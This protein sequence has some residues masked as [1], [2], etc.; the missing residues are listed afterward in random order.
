MNKNWGKR[1]GILLIS[2]IMML[3]L[4]AC[5]GKKLV[6]N[7]DNTAALSGEYVYVPTFTPI[8]IADKG[9]N[10]GNSL[11][12]EEKLYYSLNT[13]HPEM[14]RNDFK[15]IIADVSDLSKVETVEIQAP[16]LEDYKINMNT[17][18]IDA[19][20]NFYVL[21]DVLPSLDDSAIANT[22]AHTTY[23]VKY[24]SNGNKVYEQDLKDIFKDKNSS[25]VQSFQ[26]SKD[27]KLFAAC[28]HVIYVIDADGIHQKS[29]TTKTEW[30]NGLVSTEDGRL[31]YAQTGNKDESMEL[32]EIDTDKYT[33]G[34]TYKNIP[35]MSGLIRSGSDGKLLVKGSS[36]LYEYDCENQ[37]TTPVLSWSDSNIT[38]DYVADMVQLQDNNFLLLYKDGTKGSTE[39]VKLTKTKASEVSEKEVIVYAALTPGIS[40]V[41]RAI[42][43]FNN[44]NTQ[45]KIVKK[46]YYDDTKE[47]SQEQQDD[48]LALMYA[49]LSKD[50]PPDIIDLSQ[51]N[52]NDLVKQ[53]VLEDLTPYLEKST[54]LKKEDFVPSV[55]NAYTINDRLVTVPRVF[56]INTLIAKS[57]LVGDKPGWNLDELIQL[58]NTYPDA[59]LFAYMTKKDALQI[60]MQYNSSAFVDYKKG[61][62]SFDTPEFI[63]VLEFANRFEENQDNNGNLDMVE[64]FRQNK[65]LLIYRRL[66]ST[67]GYQI[68]LALFGEPL[69]FIGYPTSEE[70]NGAFIEGLETF[71]ITTNS[72]HKQ[73][74]WA[75]LESYLGNTTQDVNSWT[76]FSSRSDELEEQ[77]KEAMTREFDYRETKIPAASQQ[78]VDVIKSLIEGAKLPNDN[79][80]DVLKIINEE[81][82]AYFTGQKSAADVAKIIQSRVSIY[83]SE[84][85]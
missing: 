82:D 19:E 73:A 62:C 27:G 8:K 3:T 66:G 54:V 39:I 48:A 77:L 58:A 5:S 20:G 40:N 76:F 17:F 63:K 79:D 6:E 41:D 45:Y 29:I 80:T 22:E 38:G 83:V 78:Q 53:G 47:W 44:R 21:Y 24:E 56:Y 55:L 42:D 37:K 52:I 57:S 67:S 30:I 81:A 9:S 50:N 1:V 10:V 74:A 7:A 13:Y 4:V 72:S 61:I 12:K 85:S 43:D 14:E 11:L 31:F 51:L 32:V 49:D 69:T 2:G 68:D 36:Y 33:I 70:S 75:F 34:A 25:Y 65:L 60:S 26:I 59:D 71:G 23:L 35:E 46:I 28:N 18:Q 15:I 64:G 84:N 16:E